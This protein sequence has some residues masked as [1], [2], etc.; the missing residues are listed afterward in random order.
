VELSERF[1]FA[2]RGLSLR[3]SLARQTNRHGGT[4]SL[5]ADDGESYRGRSGRLLRSLEET[6]RPTTRCRKSECTST[7]RKGRYRGLRFVEH[8]CSSGL[9]F[10]TIWTRAPVDFQM[11]SPT[12]VS[13]WRF[14]CCVA[15]S[16]LPLSTTSSL[17]HVG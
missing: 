1:G 13:I 12:A 11:L 14:L 17:F 7:K 10:G 15:C 5:N 6:R 3:D 8:R 9:D 2:A 16:V 4:A